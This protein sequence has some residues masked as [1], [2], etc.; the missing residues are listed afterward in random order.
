[1]RDG[2][3]RR[4]V[5]AVALAGFR[6]NLAAWRGWRRL[7]G[8]RPYRLGGSCNLC[9]QCCEAPAIKVSRLVW[10]LP[11]QRF[12]FLW[13]QR[14]VN[15]FEL[16]GRD[17]GQRLFVFRCTHFDPVARRCDSYESRPGMCR[18]Y[19][20]IL[21]DQALPDMLPGCGYR[22]I[23]PGAE[24]LLRELRRRPLTADQD[25]KLRKGLRLDP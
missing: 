21:L 20:R 18:D 24:A 17:V 22:A 3:M 6:A 1:M 2:G 7:R 9:A 14:V 11:T 10:F 25:A 13:W 5:K 8:D 23:A 15:G 12:L 16:T 4:A 19:P